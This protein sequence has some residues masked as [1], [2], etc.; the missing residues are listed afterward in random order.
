M[1]SFNIAVDERMIRALLA[2]PGLTVGNV[3]LEA[4]VPL[5]QRT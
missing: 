1:R 3:T 5:F 2:T 4:L